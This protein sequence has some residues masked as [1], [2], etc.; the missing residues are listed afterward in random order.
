L[1]FV[2]FALPYESDPTTDVLHS[3]YQSL[4]EAASKAVRKYIDSKSGDLE[5]HPAEG[6][7]SP[8][9]YNLAMT[10]T[11]MAI[12]PRRREGT[13][14]TDR[15]GHEVGFVALN[16]TILAGTMMVKQI[17]EWSTLQ[18]GSG[19]LDNVLEAIGIPLADKTEG[20]TRL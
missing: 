6:G 12:V 15:N 20:Q 8:I 19:M 10:T 17:D 18:T 11:G 4:Y 1:P 14:I 2:H 9:S 13:T 3:M 7:S 16:G 5:L